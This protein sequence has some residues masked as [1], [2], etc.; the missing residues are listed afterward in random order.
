M[1]KAL[2]PI[3]I[4][5]VLAG[6]SSFPSNYEETI[7][8]SR[9]TQAEARSEL[10]DGWTATAPLTFVKSSAGESIRQLGALP[11][12][13][14]QR[15]VELDFM[16]G[17][18]VS[19][20]D[21]SQALR[22]QGVSLVSRLSTT[23]IDDLTVPKFKGTLIELLELLGQIHNISHEQRNGVLFLTEAARYSVAMPQNEEL[24]KRVTEGLKS[25]GL[26]KVSYDLTAGKLF[27]EAKPDVIDT[28]H[29]YLSS[30]SN[31]SAMIT[32][33]VAVLTLGHNRDRSVGFDWTSFGATYGIQGLAPG[34][35]ADALGRVATASGTGFGYTFSG[36]TFSLATAIKAMSKY[37]TARTEQNVTM[38][39]LSGMPVKISSGNEI[40][41]V[42]S[43]GSSVGA[44]GAIAGNSNT[45]I[46]KSGLELQV[47]PNYDNKDYSVVTDLKVDMSALVGFRELSAGANL[48]SLSQPEMQRL[49]FETVG[50]LAAGDTLVVGGVTYDQLSNNYQTL[51][52]L[53]AS[54]LASTVQ[55]VTRQSIY[56]VVR[57]TVV[58]FTPDA[59]RLNEELRRKQALAAGVAA[60]SATA[61]VSAASVASEGGVQ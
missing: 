54:S 29:D 26:E 8:G 17:A 13:L 4:S 20:E 5:S 38:G 10:G 1:K 48:G 45:E 27:F 18:K 50:R 21:L 16:P 15:Q 6:C 7:T 52:G 46:V 35:A 43:I 60:P 19:V 2:L 49:A 3:V 57:P 9:R 58:V 40:P 31:N 56:I 24:L 36:N 47:T 59:D 42:K 12:T 39:T 22:A 23:K 25:F 28:V 30:V 34:V 32:L 14:A 11:S 61:V 53:E 37:G 33:Q 44:G 55:K 41:Y 51:P